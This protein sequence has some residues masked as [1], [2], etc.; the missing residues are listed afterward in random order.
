MPEQ[1]E[2]TKQ[3]GIKPNSLWCA[4]DFLCVA[5]GFVYESMSKS[6]MVTYCEVGTSDVM[7][8]DANSFKR[9]FEEFVYTEWRPVRSNTVASK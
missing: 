2:V 9:N 1:H 6:W 8:I 5:M 3:Y 7:V 4:D